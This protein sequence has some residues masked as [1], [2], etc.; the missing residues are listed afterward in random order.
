M[1][2][3]SDLT[4]HDEAAVRR[5]DPSP[6]ERLDQ[7]VLDEGSSKLLQRVVNQASH[8]VVRDVHLRWEVGSPLLDGHPPV[9]LEVPHEEEVQGLHETGGVGRQANHHHVVFP[10]QV[11]EFKGKVTPAITKGK[12][13]STGHNTNNFRIFITIEL[14]KYL[15]QKQ[16]PKI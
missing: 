14:Y 6:L 8:H 13:E 11:P 15:L 2:R 9:P 7:R 12:K 1:I 3:K 4:G 16:H 5:I 10:G